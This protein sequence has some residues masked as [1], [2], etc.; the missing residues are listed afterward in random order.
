MLP[1][2]GAPSA[3]R[4]G[5]L[6]AGAL[7]LWLVRC[8]LESVGIVGPSV[9]MPVLGGG[10]ELIVLFAFFSGMLECW[11]TARPLSREPLLFGGLALALVPPTYEFVSFLSHWAPPGS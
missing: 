4:A 11:R 3:R 7:G 2:H 6:G 10:F 5:L 1:E 9:Y 8:G